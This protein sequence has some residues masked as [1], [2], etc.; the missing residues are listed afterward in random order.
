MKA[1]LAAILD[2]DRPKA[3]ALLKA[4]A[5]LAACLVDEARLCESKIFHWIYVGDSRPTMDPSFGNS[6]SIQP[7]A[8]TG[9]VGSQLLVGFADAIGLKCID[10]S[11]VTGDAGRPLGLLHTFA[12]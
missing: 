9:D 4:D 6:P 2:D 10:D 8:M 1:L 7:L 5:R 3:K 11:L 12:K